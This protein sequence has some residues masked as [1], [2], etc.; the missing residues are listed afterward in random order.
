MSSDNESNLVCSL[1]SLHPKPVVER[2]GVKESDLVSPLALAQGLDGS[3]GRIVVA[4]STYVS[5]GNTIAS[6]GVE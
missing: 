2:L 3:G 6:L 4:D 1:E 5:L